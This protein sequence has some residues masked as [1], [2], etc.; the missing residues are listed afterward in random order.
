MCN[1]TNEIKAD[2]WTFSSLLNRKKTVIQPLL[3]ALLA[4]KYP[5]AS[6]ST[7]S[8]QKV[9]CSLYSLDVCLPQR[10]LTAITTGD[11]FIYMTRPH[12]FQANLAV[13]THRTSES[14]KMSGSLMKQQPPCWAMQRKR[15]WVTRYNMLKHTSSSG[16]NLKWK[17]WKPLY[18]L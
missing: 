9:F 6:E 10:S 16:K 18:G 1:P 2:I 14:K 15:S 7:I 8:L 11:V 17:V 5:P 3:L 13:W 4:L 12:G